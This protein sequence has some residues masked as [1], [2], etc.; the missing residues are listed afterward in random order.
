MWGPSSCATG[1]FGAEPT[2]ARRRLGMTLLIRIRNAAKEISDPRNQALQLYEVGAR[3]M[4][5]ISCMC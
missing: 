1:C 3:K 2:R 5:P 4:R